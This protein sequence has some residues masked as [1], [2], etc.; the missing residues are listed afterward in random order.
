MKIKWIDM[1]DGEFKFTKQVTPLIIMAI[2]HY[3]PITAK[4]NFIIYIAGNLYYQNNFYD[5]TL[6]QAKSH[7]V[8]A[9]ISVMTDFVK[10]VDYMVWSVTN[11]D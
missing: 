5:V 3:N 11:E 6:E 8:A 4:G 10:N 1:G 2:L 9:F 7:A